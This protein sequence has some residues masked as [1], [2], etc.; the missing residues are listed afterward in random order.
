MR[1]THRPKHS[2]SGGCKACHQPSRTH[3]PIRHRPILHPSRERR[4]ASPHHEHREHYGH[5]V[6]HKSRPEVHLET[7]PCNDYYIFN[8]TPLFRIHEH[9][10]DT[11]SLIDGCHC[12]KRV[13]EFLGHDLEGCPKQQH[14]LE[15]QLAKNPTC[16]KNCCLGSYPQYIEAGMK[17]KAGCSDHHNNHHTK[18]KHCDTRHCDAHDPISLLRKAARVG[19]SNNK[20]TLEVLGDTTESGYA[21][22]R[23][24][25]AI[26]LTAG[27]DTGFG[28]GCCSAGSQ[29]FQGNAASRPYIPVRGLEGTEAGE[30]VDC[31]IL[32]QECG[33]KFAN[34]SR[35]QQYISGQYGYG[36]RVVGRCGGCQH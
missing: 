5:R 20:Q 2:R 28:V 1:M 12:S 36:S 15:L 19:C 13:T 9:P 3:F 14:P 16:S 17:V 27:K 4:H 25:G 23:A 33:R 31:P 18:A 8:A 35:V 26:A 6:H 22:Q 10:S 29:S 30:C 7:V 34:Q 24:Y 21:Q 32:H 11:C